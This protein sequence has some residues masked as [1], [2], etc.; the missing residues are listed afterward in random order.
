LDQAHYLL[1]FHGLRGLQNYHPLF[2]HFPIGFLFGATL[3][4]GLAWVAR[5][6]TWAWTGLW[7]LLLGTLSSA[8][9]VWTGL[10][11][12]NS[13]MVAQSVR[14]HILIYHRALMLIVF[15]LSLMLSLWALST[16]PMPQ[17]GRIAFVG[18]LLLT[19]AL[20]TIGADFGGWMVYGYNAGGSLPQPIEFSP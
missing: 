5:R 9:A 2:I 13:V 18:L 20:I 19:A 4:Y 3:V 6:E 10:G 11:A 7:M 8:A 15:A 17:R 12:W 1:A 16:R 14:E